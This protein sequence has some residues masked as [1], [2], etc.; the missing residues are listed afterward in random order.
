[1][2]TFTVKSTNGTLTMSGNT[3][4]GNHIIQNASTTTVTGFRIWGMGTNYYSWGP[5]PKVIA[6]KYIVRCS[7]CGRFSKI[8]RTSGAFYDVTCKR[9][10]GEMKG[11]VKM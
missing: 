5:G 10:L 3:V 7:G 4:I 11:M 6:G 1:M 8:V 9:C 2:T